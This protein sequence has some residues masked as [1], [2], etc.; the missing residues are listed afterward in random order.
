MIIDWLVEEF[1]K[2][3]S[4]DLKDDKVAL[5]RLKA[6]EKA[7]IELSSQMETEINLPFLTADKSGPKHLVIKLSHSKLEDLVSKL[8]EH[9]EPC[10][11]HLRMPSSALKTYSGSDFGGRMTLHAS[12]Y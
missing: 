11:K 2:Q 5:Q 10:Q 6:A 7:K 8:I 3:E 1:K 4:M 12:R 9:R